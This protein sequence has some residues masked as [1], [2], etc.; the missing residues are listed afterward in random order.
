[1]AKFQTVIS[2]K[3]RNNATKLE[4]NINVVLVAPIK[5]IL[6]VYKFRYLVNFR[7]KNFTTSQSPKSIQFCLTKQQDW[8]APFSKPPNNISPWKCCMI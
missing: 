1:M 4:K 3:L 6:L 5:S 7:F 2:P 8:F